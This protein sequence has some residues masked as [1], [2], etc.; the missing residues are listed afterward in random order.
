MS[1]SP[2]PWPGIHIQDKLTKEI[3]FNNRQVVTGSD[4]Q[5]EGMSHL[6]TSQSKQNQINFSAYLFIDR[7][8]LSTIFIR[9]LFLDH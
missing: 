6:L 1:D 8:C 7:R 3:L 5:Q 9:I 2:S 4:I